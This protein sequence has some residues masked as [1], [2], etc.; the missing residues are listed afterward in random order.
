MPSKYG[1]AGMKSTLT[2]DEGVTLVGLG[3]R[4]RPWPR[5]AARGALASGAGR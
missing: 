3:N 2:R 1:L 5:Q 4:P